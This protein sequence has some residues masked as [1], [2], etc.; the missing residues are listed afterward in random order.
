MRDANYHGDSSF[1]NGI[2]TGK[3]SA[4]MGV[5]GF[6]P[7]Q[8]EVSRFKLRQTFT[9]F[10]PLFSEAYRNVEKLTHIETLNRT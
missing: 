4:V 8:S 3:R 1:S 7:V 2:A 10:Q 5:R 6:G 9:T